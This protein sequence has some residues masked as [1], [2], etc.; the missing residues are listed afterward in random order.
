MV[1]V[2]K[3]KP[4]LEGRTIL[5]NPAKV[6]SRKGSSETLLIPS[7]LYAKALGRRSSST[8]LNPRCR[9]LFILSLMKIQV[10]PYDSRWPAHFETHR[11]EIADLLNKFHP[12]IDH[13]GS[14][15]VPGLS[16][17]PVIDIA[18]GLRDLSLLDQAVEPLVRAGYLYYEAFN[19]TMPERRLFVILDA[20]A[21]SDLRGR[22]FR[23]ATDMPHDL[24]NRYRLAHVHVWVH[25]SPEWMRHLIF[26]D[27]LRRHPVVARQYALLKESL[28]KKEW[29]HGMAYNQGKNDFLQH[30][31][32][33]ALQAF[34]D[35]KDAATSAEPD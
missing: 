13:I 18:V 3:R 31:Q 11:K 20:N 12:V 14:T 23:S 27:Y 22:I 4:G 24:V 21:P 19:E 1:I 8:C 7:G 35:G 17:K 6:I 26:R 34:R 32:A 28:A 9:R 10:V 30:H 2:Y 5:A 16:A 29:E 33:L 15:A 25:G